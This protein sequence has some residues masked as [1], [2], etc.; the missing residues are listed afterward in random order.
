MIVQVNISPGGVPKLPVA[1]AEVG[2]LGLA[3]DDHHDKAFHGGPERAVCLFALELIEAL[4]AEGHRIEPGSL[5]QNVTTRG[6]D[7]AR[8]SPGARVRLGGDV[9]LEI[10]RYAPPC[11][12]IQRWFNGGDF[13]R[14]SQKLHP[15]W[16]RTYARVLA[17]GTIRPG[18]PIELADPAG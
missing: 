10:L 15:G 1:F 12:T 16:S 13:K 6:I 4:A 3:G 5:G 18:D 11:R 17:P 9:L 2:I 14:I 8:V 7:W